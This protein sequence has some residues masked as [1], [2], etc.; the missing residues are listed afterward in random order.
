MS[1]GVGCSNGPGNQW[2]VI[3]PSNGVVDADAATLTTCQD[4]PGIF[5]EASSGS[6]AC[7]DATIYVRVVSLTQGTVPWGFCECTSH[8]GG[9]ATSLWGY[10]GTGLGGTGRCVTAGDADA[11]QWGKMWVRDA[12]PTKVDLACPAD[13]D[14]G[15]EA[16]EK[17]Y[18][19]PDGTTVVTDDTE[20]Y[21]DPG[22]YGMR[23][24]FDGS[25]RA[26]L[27]TCREHP[28]GGGNSAM[29]YWLSKDRVETKL[30]I[31]FPHAR[32]LAYV[33]LRPVH[34]TDNRC[35]YKV[36][37]RPTIEGDEGGAWASVTG[38]GWTNP[39]AL[40][41]GET[42]SHVIYATVRSVRVTLEY[43]SGGCGS[44]GVGLE[45]LAFY[46]YNSTLDATDTAYSLNG[47][48]AGGACALA[49]TGA[50]SSVDLCRNVKFP[51]GGDH[52]TCTGTNACVD[53]DFP[54]VD[55]ANCARE[56]T[57]P[58][59]CA[60]MTG[61]DTGQQPLVCDG[62][63][64]C[65]HMTYTGTDLT[66]T[67][68]GCRDMVVEGPTSLSCTGYEA[69]KDMRITG[70][71]SLTCN[72]YEACRG[73]DVACKAGSNCTITCTGKMH[74]TCNGIVVRGEDAASLSVSATVTS[75]G[76][77]R[78]QCHHGWIYHGS[79]I[80]QG[81][82]IRCPSGAGECSVTCTGHGAG[83]YSCLLY[84]SP[85]PRD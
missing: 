74:Y 52:L 26:D 39:S 51:C 69:C 28:D 77:S 84:T 2:K 60:G 76:Q 37:V 17:F 72:G 62:R 50:E 8:T 1:F 43:A 40:S 35:K 71:V 4:Q 38:A 10:T 63:A 32:D 21:D 15:G 65:R 7:R 23:N 19:A 18:M 56:C 47:T 83:G 20:T 27:S 82:D 53:I 33:A 70:I 79:Y 49:C 80:A 54:C 59:A 31:T 58:D 24:L 67:R 45:E 46:A 44:C 57:G 14:C 6:G 13:Q 73:M 41:F 25:N 81:A 30:V 55:D 61:F 34:R 22:W 78:D 9:Q 29:C 3:D 48:E 66:C 64:A 11:T 12:R 36:E 68:G 42:A 75:G 85:S 5:S 16:N